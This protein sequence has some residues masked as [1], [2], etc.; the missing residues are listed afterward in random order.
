[1]RDPD[2]PDF[3]KP[4]PN[5][6]LDRR[7]PDMRDLDTLMQDKLETHCRQQLSA[8]LDGTL[9]PDQAR[10]LLRRLQH[11]H[12]L[13]G[14]WERW[15]VYGDLMR[16]S[17]PTLLPADFSQ[18][19]QAALAGDGQ[20][21][22]AVAGERSPRMRWAGWAGGAALAAS[23][24]VAALFV[25]Q[26]ASMNAGPADAGQRLAASAPA[27][28][29]PSRSTPSQPAST[30]SASTQPRPAPETP[31]PSPLDAAGTIA[32]TA[33]AAAAPRATRRDRTPA[34]HPAVATSAP[35]VRAPEP[36]ETAPVEAFA[37]I[38]AQAPAAAPAETTPSAPQADSALQ[39]VAAADVPRPASGAAAAPA[40]VDELFVGEAVAPSR[41]WPRAILPGLSGG[42]FTVEYGGNAR[43]DGGFDYFEPQLP[44]EPPPP[45]R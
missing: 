25:D 37:G 41:P 26:R 40:A 19:V 1:M 38:D 12:E 24:A 9:A 7:N 3:H 10:F 29:S 14:C 45:P 2:M 36:V 18:R 17:V 34:R 8:M 32:A 4:G 22:A 28:T 11:D 5:S 44:A 27:D 35:V 39:A 30:R 42:T 43:D 21:Q 16:G 33:L 20:A 6:E 15:Q 13:A 31:A 23:V